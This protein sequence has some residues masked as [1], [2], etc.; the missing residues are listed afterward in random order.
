MKLTEPRF[1]IL[2]NYRKKN[3]SRLI[4]LYRVG[5]LLP[6][7]GKMIIRTNIFPCALTEINPKCSVSEV[8]K[9]F[10][11]ELAKKDLKGIVKVRGYY[12]NATDEFFKSKTFKFSIE[13]SS[14]VH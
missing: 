3:G 7:G 12:Q 5:F 10:A 14:F 13:T 11:M 1:L 9:Q 8:Q 4:T 6:D 2:I